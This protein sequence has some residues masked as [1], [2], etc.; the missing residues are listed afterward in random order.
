MVVTRLRVPP[1]EAAAFSAA[2]REAL[3]ELSVRPGYLTGELGR[4]VDDQ[5]LWLLSSRW[6]GVGAYR[7]GL[8]AY[9]V[10]MALAPLMA[11]VVN[12]PS[13]YD[14]VVRVDADHGT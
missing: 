1:G 12:E 14:V 3:A 9:D 11:Y 10:K 6:E 4:A 13:A 7:R 8:S 2:A 5:D